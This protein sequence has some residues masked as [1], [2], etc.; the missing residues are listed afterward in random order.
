MGSLPHI[1]PRRPLCGKRR[2]VSRQGEPAW[3]CVICV[4][5]PAAGSGEPSSRWESGLDTGAARLR[6]SLPHSGFSA[7]LICGS[8]GNY[9]SS[10]SIAQS[11]RTG[12]S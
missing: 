12:Q 6:S 7:R 10:I 3:M 11:V 8:R 9:K 1:L 5:V 4:R 2:C